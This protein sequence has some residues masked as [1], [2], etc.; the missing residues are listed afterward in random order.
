MVPFA[1]ADGADLVRFVGA[2]VRVGLGGDAC[3]LALA[4]RHAELGHKPTEGHWVISSNTVREH[5]AP[6]RRR[7][8][9]SY[10]PDANSII[11]VVIC[12]CR[13]CR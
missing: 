3:G 5:P 8:Q 9:R 1:P 10:R 2:A 11:S 12:S 4:Q 13:A 6:A 7:S